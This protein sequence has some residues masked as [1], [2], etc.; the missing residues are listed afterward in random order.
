M[1]PDSPP[2]H[3]SM[4]P[5]RRKAVKKEAPAVQVIRILIDL[6]PASPHLHPAIKALQIYPID[7]IL[8]ILATV[9]ES[10]Q[11]LPVLHQIVVD[12]H[13]R[14]MSATHAAIEGQTRH[15]RIMTDPQGEASVLMHHLRAAATIEA[16]VASRIVVEDM[17]D[18][19]TSTENVLQR[20]TD[21]PL[22]LTQENGEHTNAQTGGLRHA[23]SMMTLPRDL[24]PQPQQD[25]DLHNQILSTPNEPQ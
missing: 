1:P 11:D 24:H 5:R 8:Q 22:G 6:C 16:T 9:S 2:D 15:M 4:V 17:R 18:R 14:G 12:R 7:R 21:R 23:S 13:I 25:L 3:R 20:G 10:L 19:E